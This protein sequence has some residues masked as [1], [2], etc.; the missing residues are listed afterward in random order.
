LAN[1]PRPIIGSIR[2]PW[3]W[4]ISL[5]GYGCDRKGAL[6][7]RVTSTK[8]WWFDLIFAPGYAFRSLPIQLK[9]PRQLWRNSYRSVDD[10]QA[11]REWLYLLCNHDRQ[12]EMAEGYDRTSLSTFAGL[13]TFRYLRLFGRDVANLFEQPDSFK[14][15]ADLAAFDREQNMLTG[16][17][18]NEQLEDDFIKVLTQCGVQL[19]DE[20]IATIRGSKKTNTSSRKRSVEYYY[21]R[22]TLELIKHRDQFI[23]EKYGYATPSL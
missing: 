16:T 9:K 22:D 1:D 20:Q 18:R 8:S 4:Y 7:H 15:A 21:D 3:D 17:I 19:S 12:R 13:M 23:I 14:S 10:P 11:F 2:N 5:W 6:Y